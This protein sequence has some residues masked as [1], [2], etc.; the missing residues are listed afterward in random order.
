MSQ[1]DDLSPQEKARMEK[2]LESILDRLT[3]AG[4]IESARNR[5]GLLINWTAKGTESAKQLRMLF[6]Q[7]GD[8]MFA[9]ELA[10]LL[11][12]ID[13]MS[14]GGTSEATENKL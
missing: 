11:N 10:A 14:P 5:K 12:I 3:Q 9:D 7:L 4:W 13:T 8:E 6:D 1:G 2:A